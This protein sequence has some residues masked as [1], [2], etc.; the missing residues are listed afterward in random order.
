MS[1]S[2]FSWS[3]FVNRFVFQ[4]VAVPRSRHPDRYPDPRL[5]ARLSVSFFCAGAVHHLEG[6]HVDPRFLG[7]FN[8]QALDRHLVTLMAGR[9][10]LRGA[11]DH[12]SLHTERFELISGQSS[13]GR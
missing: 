11:H 7:I 1:E 6:A 4:D 8:H 10:P 12:V 9:V 3:T 13:L 2:I 5:T